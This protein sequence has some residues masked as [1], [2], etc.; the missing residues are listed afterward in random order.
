LAEAWA[1]LLPVSCAACGAADVVVCETCRA[2]LQPRL[3]R[4]RAGPGLPVP[5]FAA[6]NYGGAVAR[7]LSAV[8]EHGR[9]DALR[10]LVP[11]LRTAIGAALASEPAG[12]SE[13]AGAARGPVI[14]V[15][16]PS[17]AA[18]VRR[19]GTRPVDDLVRAAGYPIARGC[20]LTV[21]RAIADQA[22]LSADER[23]A[24]LRGAM[25]AS[26]GVSNRPVILVD[27]VVTTGSTLA[28]AHRAIVERGGQVV[29]AACLARTVKRKVTRRELIGD[30]G[31]PPM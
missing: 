5:V 28:E 17:A 24:N 1:V 21:T 27:D 4:V 2:E 14:L 7:V 13:R 9:T 8:K 30:S 25:R 31:W 23:R 20:R 29:A 12:V 15:T 22:G 11:G 6:L 16:M 26:A 18:A 3:V 10:C 19:R